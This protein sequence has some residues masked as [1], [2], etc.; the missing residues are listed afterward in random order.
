M[1]R[2]IVKPVAI[3]VL[4]L[5]LSLSLSLLLGGCAAVGPDY[6]APPLPS[7]A[8]WQ[9]A[10]PHHGSTVQLADWW[11]AF[12]DP[13]VARLV[14]MAE[15]DSPSLAT[16]AANI[17]AARATLGSARASAAP[18]LSGSGSVTRSR[19]R[20]A[21]VATDT[22]TR[23][24]SLDASW[25]IDLFGKLRRS[26]EAAQARVDA[27]GADWHEARVSLAAEVADTYV[28]YRACRLLALQDE[29]ELRSQLETARL[30]QV[31]VRAGFSAASDSDLAEASAAN[32]SATL[33][34]QR[35]ECD[36]L[37]KSLVALTGAD[38]PA[39]RTLIDATPASLPVP[40]AFGVDG[41]PVDLLRQRPDLVASERA[42]AAA[43]AEIG[44][45]EAGRYPSFS[46]G[47]TL[48]VSSSALT[49]STRTASFGPS[50]SIPLLDGGQAR[51]A[52]DSAQ[53]AYDLALA[54]YRS[55]LRS[56]VK[57]VETA[58]VNLDGAARRS[59][60]A[61]S[62]AERYRRYF[63]AVQ[64]DWRAG[65]SSLMTLEEA[66]RS[67]LSAETTLMTL[68]RDQVRDWVAL[69]KALGGGW[70][71]DTVQAA[72]SSPPGARP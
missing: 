57:E 25:E 38:E 36:G 44:Q 26:R 30:T 60:D 8:A 3:G 59:H 13:T 29:S 37:V 52:V 66:R 9:A 6:Q 70:T 24:G 69:Y 54:N 51:S 63:T 18:S 1:S 32:A 67:A 2:F 61:R 14:Q 55:A 22:T 62:A 71:A 33:T 56:A 19:Q 48:S 7:P 72:T 53:A 64:A 21:G 5:S 46:L 15:A 35:T 45:A 11:A 40:D 49:G 39:L 41:V 31:K 50:L 10:L 4:S 20:T 27:R 17:A 16:A 34:A 23:S 68:Q 65:R 58:L 42:L 43:S 28:Q 12:D 47:G